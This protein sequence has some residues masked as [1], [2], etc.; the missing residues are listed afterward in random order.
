MGW[1]F[2]RRERNEMLDIL[3]ASQ[4]VS[5]GHWYLG[6]ADAVTQNIDIIQDYPVRYIV[7]LAGDHVYKMDYEAMLRQHIATGADVPV[8]CVEVPRTEA[9]DFGVMHVQANMRIRQFFEKPDDTQAT[10]G[11][12]DVALASKGIYA[13]STDRRVADECDRLSQSTAPTDH[14]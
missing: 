9:S 5:E 7:V 3:P 10:P 12:P 13:R 8:G 11:Y 1:N 4:R 6:T 2:F 14:C